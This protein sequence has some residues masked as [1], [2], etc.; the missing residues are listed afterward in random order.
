MSEMKPDKNI[1]PEILPNL[2]FRLSY[3]LILRGELSEIQRL[4]KIIDENIGNLHVVHS[5]TSA[6]KLYISEN[7][8]EG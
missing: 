4:L 1:R 8:E 7:E 5:M 2:N 6:K 3:A